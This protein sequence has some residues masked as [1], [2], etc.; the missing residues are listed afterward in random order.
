MELENVKLKTLLEVTKAVTN[1]DGGY[2]TEIWKFNTYLITYQRFS[3]ILIH[4]KDIGLIKVSDKG[5]R[6]K[7]I[8]LTDKGKRLL[9]TLHEVLGY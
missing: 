4:M 8:H 3:K 9:D 7:Y 1:C 6:R 2:I 5:G